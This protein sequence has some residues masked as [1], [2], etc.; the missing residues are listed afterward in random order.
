MD[1]YVIPLGADRYELFC[2]RSSVSPT[3]GDAV[4][5]QADGWVGRLRQRFTYM[6]NEAER[7]DDGLG[8]SRGGTWDRLQHRLL[9]WVAERVAE[10]RLLW[11]LRRETSVHLVHPHD[12]SEEK[13]RTLVNRMLRRDH[14]RHR[15]WFLVHGVLLVVSGVLAIVPGPNLIAYYFAFRFVGHWLSM[16]G[17]SQ[18]LHRVAWNADANVRLS[19]LRRIVHDSAGARETALRAL[20]DDLALP[21]LAAF[22]ERLALR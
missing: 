6:V 5:P 10:Q 8:A 21:S 22:V 19:D 15:V 13:A 20:G 16:R 18:G 3:G 7:P 12:V 1:V 4:D 9:A 2:E 11:N 17:A 14:D